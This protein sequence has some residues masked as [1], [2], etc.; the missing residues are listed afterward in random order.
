MAGRCLRPDRVASHTGS[1]RFVMMRKRRGRPVRGRLFSAGRDRATWMGARWESDGFGTGGL[2]GSWGA[3]AWWRRI[4]AD[5]DQGALALV[6]GRGLWGS[7]RSRGGRTGRGG[8]SGQRRRGR[9]PAPEGG[10]PELGNT[11]DPSDPP[12][13]LPATGV[14]P[15]GGDHHRPADR[16]RRGLGIQWAGPGQSFD[17]GRSECVMV[18]LPRFF[19]PSAAPGAHLKENPYGQKGERSP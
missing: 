6:A 8:A 3:T 18:L 17:R 2:R 10:V 1:W 5:L 4:T 13:V 19:P 15:P 12:P 7:G 11:E 14:T 9:D 16:R